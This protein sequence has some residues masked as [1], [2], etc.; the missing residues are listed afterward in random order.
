MVIYL[1]NN[2]TQLFFK[3]LP[4]PSLNVKQWTIKGLSRENNLESEM[5]R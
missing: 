3:P 1:K 5:K 2:F 4:S